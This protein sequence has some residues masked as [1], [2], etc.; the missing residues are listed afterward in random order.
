[1]NRRQNNSKRKSGRRN[2][3]KKET[4]NIF[5]T[6]NFSSV[7]DAPNSF[8]IIRGIVCRAGKN[9]AAEAKAAGLPHT[10]A[11]NNQ[12]IQEKQNGEEE[13]ISTAETSPVKLTTF[14]IRCEPSTVLYA[15]KK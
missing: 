1:M 7:E 5:L 8:E 9:V 2:P 3:G 4:N 10:F 12:I 13:V 6:R 11:R 14:Y 15:R